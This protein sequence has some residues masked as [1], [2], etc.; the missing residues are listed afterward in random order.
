MQKLPI[1]LPPAAVSSKQIPLAYQV[2]VAPSYPLKLHT[3]DV[4]A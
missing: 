3:Q 4:R 1:R 2:L